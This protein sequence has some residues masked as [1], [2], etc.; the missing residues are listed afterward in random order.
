M[1]VATSGVMTTPPADSP[2]EATDSATERRRV[3]QRATRV[4]PGTSEEAEKPAPNSA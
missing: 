1:R 3:N 4:V 2:V